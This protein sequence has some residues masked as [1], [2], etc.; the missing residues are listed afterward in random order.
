MSSDQLNSSATTVRDTAAAQRHTSLS[1]AQ[2]HTGPLESGGP[3]VA[4][5]AK[6]YDIVVVL[7]VAFLL[8]SNISATKLIA[9]DAYVTELIFDGGAILFPLTYVLGD[10]LAE[11]Y[12][13][14]R[15]TRA[16]FLGFT[17]SILASL[18]FFLVVMAPPGPGYADQAA[19]EAVLGFVPRIV[20][21]SLVG[22]LVGQFLNAWVLVRIRNAWGEKHLWAR[23]VGST[24]VGEA[25]D[26]AL[27]C[28]VAFAGVVTNGELL[29]YIVVGYVYKV[30]VEIIMLP[31][32]YRVIAFVRQYEAS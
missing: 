17:V 12:G 31:V 14:K 25:A 16:I 21:A 18:T 24:L 23:L 1:S 13:L 28:T 7:F 4:V 20:A 10:V 27:F 5:T 19:F 9:V 11:V 30:A 29:N 3:T 15:A 26:T 8:I 22:Y 6:A 32:T 2:R